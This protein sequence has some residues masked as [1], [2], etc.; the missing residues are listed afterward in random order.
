MNFYFQEI[1]RDLRIEDEMGKMFPA[2]DVFSYSI[3]A[4]V[5]DMINNCS[6]SVSG[7]IF[8]DDVH[9]VLTVP[10]IWSDAAKQFMREAATKEPVRNFQFIVLFF[11]FSFLNAHRPVHTFIYRLTDSFL[12]SPTP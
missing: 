7:E 12:T 8:K 5:D 6:N 3:A 4:L 10:A 2:I 1:F 11:F 9:W